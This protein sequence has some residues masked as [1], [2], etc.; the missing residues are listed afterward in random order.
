MISSPLRV[1]LLTPLPL[2]TLRAPIMRTRNARVHIR[3]YFYYNILIAP[4]QYEIEKTFE[5][6]YKLAACRALHEK[7]ERGQLAPRCRLCDLFRLNDPDRDRAIC[8]CPSMTIRQVL[9]RI[10]TFRKATFGDK[11]RKTP[12]NLK[13]TLDFRGFFKTTSENATFL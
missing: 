12:E 9:R 2:I 7:T 10:A 1:F 11:I 4:C 3:V 13:S 6:F 8:P 5:H